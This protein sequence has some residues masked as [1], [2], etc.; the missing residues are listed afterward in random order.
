MHTSRNSMG[1]YCTGNTPD[2]IGINDLQVIRKKQ[3]LL[4]RR[5]VFITTVDIL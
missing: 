1:I 5:C 3:G 2:L 4:I